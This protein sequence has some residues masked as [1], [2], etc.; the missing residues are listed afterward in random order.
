RHEPVE[1]PSWEPR[2]ASLT[3]T[4][5]DATLDLECFALPHSAPA[6][7]VEAPLVAFVASAPERVAGA[8]ALYEAPLMRMPHRVLAGLAS[9]TYDP[10]DTFA[11]TAQV[12]PFAREIMGV[13]EPAMAAGA[14]GFIGVLK[15]YPGDSKDYYVP[16]DAIAR[17]LPGV[18][19]RGSDGRQLAQALAAGPVTARLQVE[20]VSRTITTYN[21]VGEL[22]GADDEIVIIGSHH[23]G[24]WSSAVEDGSGIALVLAQAEYWSRVPQEER[25][26]RLVF[27]LNS[28]HMAGGAGCRA[29]V[30]AHRDELIRTVLEVHVEHAANEFAEVDGVLQP[31]GHPEARWWF[32]SRIPRLEA[33]VKAAIE[34][35]G[36]GRSLLMPPT[37]FGPR[38]TTDGSEFY[39]AGVP[40][41][42]YLTAPF[43][44]FDSCDTMDKIHRPSLVPVTR[45]AIR[46]IESTA[47]VSAADMRA[48]S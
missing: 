9:W 40:I 45:A 27:L 31:T 20:S 5:G 17:P 13:M 34:A 46:I 25:P 23:D 48:V 29:F 36:L 14:A 41:V 10:G 35:E 2:S 22:P 1:L 28:G 19:V 39:V 42:N 33:S 47:G 8:I 21:V 43:Y 6:A 7:D 15:G 26:H 37:V 44:L 3:V 18:W 30:E 12:L 16:Y 32:T 38:P 4:A 24:P 11:E